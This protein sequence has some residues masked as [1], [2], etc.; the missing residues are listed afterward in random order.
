MDRT[1][2]HRA[3]MKEKILL[4]C[5]TLMCIFQLCIHT[6]AHGAYPPDYTAIY[7]VDK[8]GATVGRSTIVLRQSKDEIHYSQNVELVGFISWFKSDR[9]AENSWLSNDGSNSFLL[10]KYQYIHS[11]SKKNRDSLIE[12]T[13]KNNEDNQLTGI[14]TG[15]MRGKT[16]SIQSNEKVWDTL[17]FQLAL[18]NDVSN[19][20]NVFHYNVISRGKIKLYTF[21][22]VSKEMIEINDK[23][24]KTIVLERHN[25][26]KFSKIWLA[27]ELHYIPVL[28]EKYEDDDLDST[29]TLD[30]I[31]F[32]ESQKQNTTTE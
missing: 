29:M 20:K 12:A 14:I 25:G 21:I 7:D 5:I 32:N 19:N 2:T 9:V 13:W 27:T 3:A 24:Y 1:Q 26:K 4:H 30:T 31:V 10:K 28:I 6:T 8:F 11:H 22:N 18:M 23:E 17:S 16:F 15:V